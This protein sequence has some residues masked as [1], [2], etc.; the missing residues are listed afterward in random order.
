MRNLV[1]VS[2][3]AGLGAALVGCATET[4]S[5]PGETS[6][7]TRSAT[8][9]T[10][11][12]E[13]LAVRFFRCDNG[14]AFTTEN[15]ADG[16]FRLKTRDIGYDLRPSNGAFVGDGV[17]YRRQGATATLEGAAG[18]PYLNCVQS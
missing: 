9:P 10:T 13:G 15:F 8:S 5:M 14:A 4:S 12:F 11:E 6:T 2:L 1:S 18:G 3:L 7:A 16:R 17:T